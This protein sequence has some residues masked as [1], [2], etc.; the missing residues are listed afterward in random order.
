MKRFTYILFT[1]FIFTNVLAQS[2][3]KVKTIR[4]VTDVAYSFDTTLQDSV[5]F[6]LTPEGDTLAVKIYQNGG[7]SI[8]FLQSQ[9][10]RIDFF[11]P[12]IPAN[13]DTLNVNRNNTSD[14]LKNSEGWRLEFPRFYQGSDITFEV[15]HSTSTYGITYSLEWDGIKKANRWT[16][17]ELFA[18]N[19]EK[20]VSRTDNFQEDPNIPSQYRTT[21][22]DYKNTGYSRGHLCPSGDRLCSIEQNSQTFYLS[23][24]MP[25][26]QDHNGGVWNT[27]EVKVRDTWAPQNSNDTLYVVKAA[28]IDDANIQT[29]TSTG[30]IVP[31]F[32]Y[33]ALLYYDKTANTYKAAGI[34]SPHYGG[35]TAEYITIDELEKRTGIDFF[36]NLPDGRE[37]EVEKVIDL[38]FWR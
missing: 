7:N 34:W 14:L 18:G 11:D 31:Q 9:I 35:S 1:I 2:S 21:L 23:N 17:Y 32:F 33:M 6:I 15:T 28:T 24:M 4:L 22:L 30:L 36:C 38:N 27:L 16:C 29:Y 8:D 37:C 3:D 10:L 12:D 26:I 20:T 25:Q 19:M 5:R 13:N